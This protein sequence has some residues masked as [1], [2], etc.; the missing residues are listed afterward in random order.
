MIPYLSGAW[1]LLAISIRFSFTR[2]QTRLLE[3]VC[4]K[5]STFDGKGKILNRLKKNKIKDMRHTLF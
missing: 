5:V 4:F 1:I 3:P 2:F